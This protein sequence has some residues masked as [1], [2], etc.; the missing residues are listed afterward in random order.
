MNPAVARKGKSFAGAVGYIT[1]DIG[2]D[3]DER[4]AFSETLNMRTNDPEKAAKVMAWTKY[5]AEQLK[6]EAGLK[7]TG[8]KTEDPVYH[9]TL[10]WEPG[11]K[12]DRAH[13][14]KT[15]K[16]ALDALGFG[17]HEAVLAVHTDKEH[18][19]IHVVVN[20][21]HPVTGKTHNPNGDQNILQRWAYEYEKGMGNVVCLE[22]AIKYETDKTLKAEYQRRLTAELESGKTRESKPRPQWDAENDAT[23][24]KS[25]AYQELKSIFAGRVRELAQAGRE[26]AVRRATEWDTLKTRHAAEKVE[27]QTKQREA[28]QNRRRFNQVSGVAPY[29]WKTYQAD[30]AAMKTQHTAEVKKLRAQ[31]KVKDAPAVADMKAQQ[32]DAWR[33][34]FKLERAANGGRLDKALKL[35]ASTPVGKQGPEYRDHLAA[36]FNGTV[37][38]GVRQVAFSKVLATEKR[39]F[40]QGLAQKSAPAWATLK[41]GQTQQLASLRTRFDLARAQQKTRSA[42][43]VDVRTADQRARSELSERQASER[44]ALKAKHGEE[45]TTQ[46]GAWAQLNAD[47]AAG[48]GAYKQRRATQEASTSQDAGHT[49]PDLFGSR[50]MKG[51]DYMRGSAGPSQGGGGGRHITRKGP[52]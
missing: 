35:V 13:M 17:E 8:R 29:P 49:K 3:T 33:Q 1:H 36:L 12:P 41:E 18:Q 51:P 39:A 40:Y 9:F 42:A 44:A 7:A 20:R 38:A 46:Q 37:A 30:R 2:K 27:L 6:Q 28:F 19:H 24:P 43:V 23:H 47:R 10:N 22:R 11:N 25:Q 32:K 50:R 45:T 21:I 48:W 52:K 26:S 14:V 15:A 31:L 5:H 34:F 4:V 16:S